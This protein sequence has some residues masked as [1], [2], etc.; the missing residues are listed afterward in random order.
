VPL[1]RDPIYIAEELP[2]PQ[3]THRD[4]HDL[5]GQQYRQLNLS[6]QQ[7]QTVLEFTGCHP[8]LLPYCLLQGADSALACEQVLRQSPIPTQ[9]FTRFHAEADRLLLCTLGTQ[10]TLGRFTLWSDDELLRR[11]YWANLI[12]RHGQN[13]VWH[14]E[15]IR[16]TGR[17]VLECGERRRFA[18]REAP[19]ERL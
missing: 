15:F 2:I 1:G 14:C 9:L 17:E 11:L 12:T 8:R 19:G 18:G 4:L 16:Q 5:F 3:L 13:F 10:S 7:L 6:P